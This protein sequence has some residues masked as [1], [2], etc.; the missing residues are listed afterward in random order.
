MQFVEQK[1]FVLEK[2]FQ[3]HGSFLLSIE[4]IIYSILPKKRLLVETCWDW[5]TIFS[6]WEGQFPGAMLVLGR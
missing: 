5:K 6:F 1:S 4:K 3:L 2:D